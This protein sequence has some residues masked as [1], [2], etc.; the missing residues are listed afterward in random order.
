MAENKEYFS[1]E[2][3][4]GSIQIS[5]EVVASVAAMAATTI[6]R[7]AAVAAVEFGM[8]VSAGRPA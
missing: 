5:E 6:T 2:M 7:A 8:P 1:K 3:E 4:N